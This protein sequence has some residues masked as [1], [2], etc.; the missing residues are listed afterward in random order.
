IFD[1]LIK[2]KMVINRHDKDT[3]LVELF[4]FGF[5]EWICQIIARTKTVEEA[6]E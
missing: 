2:I 6:T 1:T 3:I 5:D 4:I